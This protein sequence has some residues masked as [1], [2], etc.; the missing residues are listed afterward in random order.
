MDS[1]PRDVHLGLYNGVTGMHIFKNFF[2]PKNTII[3]ILVRPLK[4]FIMWHALLPWC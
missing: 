4:S 1:Y 2:I 3:I